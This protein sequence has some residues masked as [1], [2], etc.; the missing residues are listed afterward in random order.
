MT[1]PGRDNYMRPGYSDTP[2]RGVSARVLGALALVFGL[3]VAAYS[4][5]DAGPNAR[6]TQARSMR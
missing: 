5:H 1:E 2:S 6:R 4:G 3:G